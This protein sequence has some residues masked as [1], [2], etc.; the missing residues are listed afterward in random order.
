MEK[1]LFPLKLITRKNI[2][3]VICLAAIFG[4]FY[5]N[6]VHFFLYMAVIAGLLAFCLPYRIENGYLYRT[7]YARL[8]ISGIYQLYLTESGSITIYYTLSDSEKEYTR[9]VHPVDAEGFI[10]TLQQLNKEITILRE[11]S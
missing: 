9:V 4:L 6:Q 1:K 2:A 5:L 10:A 3:I 7:P 8:P 11:N